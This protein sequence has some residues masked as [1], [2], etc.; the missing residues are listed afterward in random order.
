MPNVRLFHFSRLNLVKTRQNEMEKKN[1]GIW[2]LKTHFW[3]FFHFR[4]EPLN[5][6]ISAPP[7]G[8]APVKDQENL[9]EHLLWTTDKLPIFFHYEGRLSKPLK[10]EVKST[11]ITKKKKKLQKINNNFKK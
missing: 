3:R 9:W 11:I 2:V 4:T 1:L 8:S 7:P 6:K 5:C 10:T